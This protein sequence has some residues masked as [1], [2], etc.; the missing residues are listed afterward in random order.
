M[1][2][3]CQNK[4][5]ERAAASFLAFSV[6]HCLV[7]F[8]LS[9]CF[10]VEPFAIKIRTTIIALVAAMVRIWVFPL[11]QRR[12][13]GFTFLQSDTY[14]EVLWR[15][16]HDPL[17]NAIQ[18]FDP[19]NGDYLTHVGPAIDRGMPLM[20]SFTFRAMGGPYEPEAERSE[21]ITTSD[22]GVGTDSPIIY[23]VDNS[24]VYTIYNDAPEPEV[25][26]DFAVADQVSG[27]QLHNLFGNLLVVF[28]QWHATVIQRAFR[29][30]LER[31]PPSYTTEDFFGDVSTASPE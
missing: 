31:H 2:G 3:N 19:R 6:L 25:E 29:R 5:T 9:L 12:P 22:Q 7:V 20:D 16:T 18:V 13:M 27:L 21:N 24:L 23:F 4:K 15:L 28:P 14:A 26:H 17:F 1:R 11:Q 10:S 8:V 30:H